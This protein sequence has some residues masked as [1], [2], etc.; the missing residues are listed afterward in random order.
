MTFLDQTDP[1]WNIARLRLPTGKPEPVTR[2]AEGRCKDYRWAPDGSRI[3]VVRYIG[4]TENVW[5]TMP[6]GSKPVQ[7]TRFPADQI[8]GLEWTADSKS[9][10]V[11]VGKQSNDAVLIRN[12]R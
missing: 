3:A 9:L 2:F 7:V 11:S 4:E 10:V 5:I 1:S 6:D 8:F 12:F